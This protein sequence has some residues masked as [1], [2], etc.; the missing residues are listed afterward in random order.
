MKMIAISFVFDYVMEMNGS[1]LYN[2]C[3]NN[4]I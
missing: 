2:N 3:N 4:C 1:D